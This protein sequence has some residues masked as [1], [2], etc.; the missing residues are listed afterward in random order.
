M[1]ITVKK[2]NG[3]TEQLNLEKMRQRII[4]EITELDRLREHARDSRAP[5]ELDQQSVG[6]LSRMD[7]MQQQAMNM[8]SETRRQHRQTMLMAALKRI[9]ECDYGYCQE[10]D[11]EIF[12]RQV[13]PGRPNGKEA[14]NR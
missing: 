14:R 10:C 3:T 11:D 9:D 5:V 8:A 2:R 12:C 6:R 1:S 4:D 7:A 13:Q